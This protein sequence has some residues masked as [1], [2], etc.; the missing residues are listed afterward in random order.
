[1]SFGRDTGRDKRPCGRASVTNNSSSMVLYNPAKFAHKHRGEY[2]SSWGTLPR[3]SNASYF[4]SQSART[5]PRGRMS[6]EEGLTMGTMYTPKYLRVLDDDYVPYL[7]P[8]S[9]TSYA[10]MDHQ[11]PDGRASAGRAQS[12]RGCAPSPSA[13][14]GRLSSGRAVNAGGEMGTISAF[15]GVPA[16][17][18]QGPAAPSVRSQSVYVDAT[19]APSL[20]PPSP[21]LSSSSSLPVGGQVPTS[22]HLGEGYWPTIKVVKTSFVTLDQRMYSNVFTYPYAVHGRPLP[23]RRASSVK[24]YSGASAGVDH[25][26]SRRSSTARQRFAAS[27]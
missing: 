5:M 24:H 14:H 2:R 23:V 15:D 13:R 12:A 20:P 21:K 18:V 7:R 26:R 8:A 4:R 3:N 27:N 16:T 6:V 19:A 1:M 22:L 25:P 10:S 11:L 17:P 9:A